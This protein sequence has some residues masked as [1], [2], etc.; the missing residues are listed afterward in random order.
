M[1][2]GSASTFKLKDYVY[3]HEAELADAVIEVLW[4]QNPRY[5]AIFDATGKQKCR[6]DV[7]YHLLY[8]ADSVDSDAWTLFFEY[9]SWV[10]TLFAG[11]SIPQE[12]LRT[13][14]AAMRDVL[15]PKTEMP[16]HQRALA[17][18][19]DGIEHFD[20]A[21]VG[22]ESYIDAS[23]PH[24]TLARSYLDSLL[25][26]ERNHA[27]QL[28]LSA[29]DNGTDVRDIYEHVFQVTQWEIGRLW[30]ENMI[31][32]AQ[33]HYCTAATQLV[34]SRLY[35]R[36]FTQ[37]KNG[38][39]FVGTSVGNELHELGIRM[40]ADFFEL[41]GW[42]TYFLGANTPAEAVIETVRQEQAD[43]LG[44]S[45][46]MTYHLRQVSQIIDSVRSVDELSQVKI[47][48]G[49]YPFNMDAQLWKKFGAD[50]HALTA[51]NAIQLSRSLV[52][53]DASAELR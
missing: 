28:I 16:S 36:I 7:I 53:V 11:L 49:G 9:I 12:S 13:A 1:I 10:K 25:K 6:Q 33:E 26:G 51:R 27:M 23:N 52:G 31:S 32:V 44:V 38:L 39:V 20:E 19:N 45:V 29:T 30:Q 17:F 42:D 34:M 24:A 46:T 50:G 2:S 4:R 18:L 14:L 8:L 3:L 41:D 21:A 48:V 15:T 35:P 5:E 37:E 47:L 22:T 43:V 40:V